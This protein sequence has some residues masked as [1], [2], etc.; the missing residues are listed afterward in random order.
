MGFNSGFKGLIKQSDLFFAFY[1]S[2]G[3]FLERS[4]ASYRTIDCCQSDS[5]SLAKVGTTWGFTNIGRHNFVRWHLILFGPQV[6]NVTSCHTSTAQNLEVAHRFLKSLWG[7]AYCEHSCEQSAFETAG[8]V[9]G[10]GSMLGGRWWESVHRWDFF[11]WPL[12]N[13]GPTRV[14]E[15]EIVLLHRFWGLFEHFLFCLPSYA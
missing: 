14:T 7:P 1:L 2:W 8:K 10:D 9:A 3:F 5:L 15:K 13:S 11:H 6:W 4:I 12:S